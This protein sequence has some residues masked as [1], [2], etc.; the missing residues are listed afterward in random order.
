MNDPETHPANLA[1]PAAVGEPV[2]AAQRLP[3]GFG[4]WMDR[5]AD[6]VH[7][8]GVRQATLAIVGSSVLLSVLLDVLLHLL[9]GWPLSTRSLLLATLLP[10][11]IAGLRD[12]QHPLQVPVTISLGV[13]AMSAATPTLD[14]LI[15]ATDQALYDA[16]RAGR[17]RV[18]TLPLSL[19]G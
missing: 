3:T 15:R 1:N 12:P 2:E 9:A 6:W 18:H 11:P 16:K 14:A 17:D 10:V 4:P 7:R 8:I 13:V 19:G 5:L